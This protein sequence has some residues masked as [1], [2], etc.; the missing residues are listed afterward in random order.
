[1]DAKKHVNVVV[2]NKAG[3]VGKS[4][5]SKHLVAPMLGADW[6]QVETF[7]DS[8]QGAKAKIAGR[9]FD[10]VAEAVLDAT[11]SLCIDIGNSNYQASLKEMRDIDG[12]A[13]RI[14]CWIIPCKESAGVMNDSLTTV[15][16]LIEKLNVDPNRIVI[17]PNAIED[18]EE[19]LD[20]F[21]KIAN[22]AKAIKFH[23]CEVAIPQNP[24]FDVFNE[25]PRTVIEIATDSTDYDAMNATETDPEKR[26]AN[27]QASLLRRRARTLA[28]R[29]HEVWTKSPLDSL[30]PT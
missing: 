17:L 27:T 9:K 4:T 1:M 3:K 16:D 6:I 26:Y 7:N 8:G 22:A 10:Y 15:K 21:W 24:K 5:I 30:D 11:R 13:D 2:I 14:H 20:G 19:G 18:P 25:D 29:L 12:F 23:F 28:G